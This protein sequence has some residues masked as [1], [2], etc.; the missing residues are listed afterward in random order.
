MVRND[1]GPNI[2]WAN[3]K[4]ASDPEQGSLADL[5]CPVEPPQHDR[6]QS[7]L[8]RIVQAKIVPQLVM[9]DKSAL[10]TSN[11][12]SVAPDGADNARPEPLATSERSS[13]PTQAD[14]DRFEVIVLYS[15]TF[16]C[17]SFV[18]ALREQ[19]VS[20]PDIYLGLFQPVAE[21]LGQR[22]DEDSLSFVEVTR[23]ISQMQTV[24]RTL[25]SNGKRQHPIDAAH[26]ILLASPSH[27]QHAL[28]M[29]IVSQ[30]FQ[31]EGWEVEG[32]SQLVAGEELHDM[33]RDEWFGVV[34]L[35]ASSEESARRLK[36][37]IDDLRKNSLNESISVIVGGHA[38]AGH[39]GL[40][41][42][43][44]ADDMAID[45][46]DAIAKAER[47]LKLSRKQGGD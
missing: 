20:L 3:E 22:W 19:G 17:F 10:L 43:V 9:A 14:R 47:L 6:I 37:V 16:D 45:A 21:H 5:L 1:Q 39:P 28:G 4:A 40:S 46:M 25:G 36:S 12:R 29:L 41:E 31:M 24:V 30:L 35:T 11:R 42:E 2:R 38:F 26:R 18:S 13:H 7:I 15:D 44:G 32:G 23:A 27:E 33:V 8:S 34:G